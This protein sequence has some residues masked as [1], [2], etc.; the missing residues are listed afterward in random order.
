M[1]HNPIIP[2]DSFWEFHGFLLSCRCIE[3][4]GL[5]AEFESAGVGEL[6]FLPNGLVGVINSTSSR[7]RSHLLVE[8]RIF[9]G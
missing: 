6:S 4:A 3:G 1:N 9:L 8:S 7:V 2:I 5:I